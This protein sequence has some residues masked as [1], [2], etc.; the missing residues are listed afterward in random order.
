[1]EK[2]ITVT[3]G[4]GSGETKLSAFDA[5]LFDAGIANYNLIRLSS[6]IPEGYEPKVEKITMNGSEDFGN[7]LYV[8]YSSQV[9]NEIGKEAWAGIGWVI[10]KE[11]PHRGI[12]VE[13]EG[14][15][16]SQVEI[17]IA[18][19]LRSMTKYRQEKFSEIHSEI[20]GIKCESK[21]VCAVVAAVYKSE[22]WE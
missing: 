5:A 7:K 17:L 22:S 13:H 14:A 20:C 1:M 2:I 4:S 9:E 11:K 12:F 15:D 16:K 19:S 10:T 8:V 18:K 3:K 21:P 6:I